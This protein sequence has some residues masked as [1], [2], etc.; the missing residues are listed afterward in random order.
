MKTCSRCG[1]EKSVSFFYFNKTYERYDNPCNPC[2]A[3]SKRTQRSE[4]PEKFKTY[5]QVY[6]LINK[7]HFN[8]YMINYRKNNP[9]KI[10]SY[11]QT[12]YE[13]GGKEKKKVYDKLNL[14]RTRERDKIR[15][16]TDI[17]FRMKKVLRT[18][19][20]KVLDGGTKKSSSCELLDCNYEFYIL[21]LESQ[22]DTKMKW[23]N[24]GEYWNID[25]VI[26]CS[27]FD[28]SNVH[29]QKKCFH[30]SNTR[31]L[32]KSEN[33]SKNDSIEWGSI[34]NHINMLKTLQL[35]YAIPSYTQKGIMAQIR[36]LG[37]GKNL[38]NELI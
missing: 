10:K 24:Y 26:P 6:R 37:Y 18:R 16:Q 1:E 31:P 11:N 5:Q 7:T 23:S 4:N 20:R 9:D 34:N 33:E 25:H 15:Y 2:R 32:I 8:N 29:D 17:Q 27:S 30:W 3:K 12:Y 38:P 13:N 22:F 19:I 36:E 35:E 14:E 28:L 21:Y